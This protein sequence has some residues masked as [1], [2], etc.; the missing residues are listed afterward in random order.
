MVIFSLPGSGYWPGKFLLC[1][2]S[3]APTRDLPEHSLVRDVF[4]KDNATSAW[5]QA[6]SSSR[7][8]PGRLKGK[9][10]HY[11]GVQPAYFLS[12][13]TPTFLFLVHTYLPNLVAPKTAIANAT[14]A[15]GHQPFFFQVDLSCHAEAIALSPGHTQ[16]QQ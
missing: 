11:G 13:S 5:G 14:D 7:G 15:L 1:A 8:L 9:D 3:G 16:E 6:F 10:T 4:L 2:F 12:S